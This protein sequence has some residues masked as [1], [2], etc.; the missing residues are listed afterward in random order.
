MRVLMIVVCVCFILLNANESLACL[1]KPESTGHAIKRLRKEA[2]VI[3]VGKVRNVRKEKGGY[4]AT[5]DIEKSW[6]G[7]RVSEFDV[8]TEGD[9]AAWFVTGRIYLVYAAQNDKHNLETDV[10]M[11]TRLL[12]YAMEDLKRLGKPRDFPQP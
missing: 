8:Y 3:F 5:F 1:C 7:D 4:I 9:C 11:R 6:K 10:C 12:V 2:K